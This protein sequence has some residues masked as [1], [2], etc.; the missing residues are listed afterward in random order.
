M[1]KQTEFQ[2]LNSKHNSYEM[3]I[4]TLHIILAPNRKPHQIK[5]PVQFTIYRHHVHSQQGKKYCSNLHPLGIELEPCQPGKNHTLYAPM[6]D[7]VYDKPTRQAGTHDTQG[8]PNTLH[9]YLSAVTLNDHV[10]FITSPFIKIEKKEV[11][12]A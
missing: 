5:C 4:Q 1:Y 8:I 11:K 12:V 6:K 10:E 3:F 7:M 2:V 9:H